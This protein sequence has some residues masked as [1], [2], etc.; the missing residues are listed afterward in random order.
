MKEKRTFNLSLTVEFSGLVSETAREL[1]WRDL[2]YAIEN[3][4]PVNKLPGYN[5]DWYLEDIKLVTTP[6]V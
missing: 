6:S 5:E 1:I 3:E 4:E 2:E